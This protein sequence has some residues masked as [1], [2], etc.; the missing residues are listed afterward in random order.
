MNKEKNSLKSIVYQETLDGIIRGEYK[1]N[2]IINEQELVAKFGFS[3]SPVREALISLCNEGV[4]HNIPRYGYEV[5]RLTSK[6]ANEI[7][8]FRFILEGGMLRD[9][10]DKITPDQIDELYRLDDLC[11]A[12]VDDMWVHWEHNINF[13]LKLL[14]YSGNAYAYQQLQRSM[15]ILKRAYAQFYWDKWDSAYN[16][17]DMRYHRAILSCIKIKDIHGALKNLELDLKDFRSI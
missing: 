15:D 14:S 10:Y 4:L 6:D 7:L 12:S 17:I 1:A 9:C 13:H 8:R 11:N 5:V 16:P 3:K 2:Q